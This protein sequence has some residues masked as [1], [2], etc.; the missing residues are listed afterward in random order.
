[1]SYRVTAAFFLIALYAED[2]F[3]CFWQ[4]SRVEFLTYPL[5]FVHVGIVGASLVLLIWTRTKRNQFAWDPET[6]LGPD[7]LLLEEERGSGS[8]QGSRRSDRRA[9][10]PV[11]QRSLAMEL[12]VL[13]AG[14]VA[15]AGIGL[16]SAKSLTPVVSGFATS[17]AVTAL[18]VAAAVLLSRVPFG[19]RFFWFARAIV[20][21]GALMFSALQASRAHDGY[22]IVKSNHFTAADDVT[23]Q[24]VF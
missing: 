8:E 3:A 20:L 22:F 10:V 23:T 24:V 16:F 17:G 7:E 4:E 12:A 6:V 11:H 14:I 5:D 15:G 9:F 19:G 1:M 2:A 21:V 13:C 18:V